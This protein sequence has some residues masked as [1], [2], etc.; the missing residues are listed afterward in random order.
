MLLIN[1]VFKR[2]D[3]PVGLLKLVANDASLAAILWENDSARRVG[4]GPLVEILATPGLSAERQ[5][6]EYLPGERKFFDV[7]LAS[8][9]HCSRPRSGRPS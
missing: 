4:L 5:L 8:P 6:A 3:S 1:L 9:A 7:P 2:I